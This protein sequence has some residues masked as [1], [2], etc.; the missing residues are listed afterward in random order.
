MSRRHHKLLFEQRTNLSELWGWV[1]LALIPREPRIPNRQSS[2]FFTT[3]EESI[4]SRRLF[5]ILFFIV[6]FAIQLQYQTDEPVQ[7]Q[8]KTT[9]LERV[10]VWVLRVLIGAWFVTYKDQAT[11]PFWR[12]D[13]I[14]ILANFGKVMSLRSV[15]F[16]GSQNAKLF[17]LP[18]N[19]RSCRLPRGIPKDR[20]KLGKHRE[21]CLN[22]SSCE[23]LNLCHTTL[24]A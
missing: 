19:G 20:Q 4:V 15:F 1:E 13:L 12:L 5:W 21:N 9:F 2:E 23:S 14:A 16:V 17:Q 22:P 18:Q 3:S 24:I 11:K 6:H 7:Q 8:A 10:P